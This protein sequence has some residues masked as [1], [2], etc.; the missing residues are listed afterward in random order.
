MAVEVDVY[1]PSGEEQRPDEEKR[2]TENGKSGGHVQKQ[3]KDT[4]KKE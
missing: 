4:L 1:M 2:Q 3:V